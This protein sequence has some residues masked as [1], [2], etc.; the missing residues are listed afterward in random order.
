M[1]PVNTHA[2]CAGKELVATQYFAEVVST[3][4]TIDVQANKEELG[5]TFNFDI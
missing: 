3:G 4:C 2:G 1:T 5:K